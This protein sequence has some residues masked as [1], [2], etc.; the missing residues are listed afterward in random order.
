MDIMQRIRH[1]SAL[2]LPL[3]AQWSLC[4]TVERASFPLAPIKREM[5][6]APDLLVLARLVNIRIGFEVRTCGTASR[7][8]FTSGEPRAWVNPDLAAMSGAIDTYCTRC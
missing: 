4:I 6:A 3:R 7:G 5:F 2:L 8:N 1:W